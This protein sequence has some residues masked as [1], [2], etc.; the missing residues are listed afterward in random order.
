MHLYLAI[1]SNHFQTDSLITQELWGR[2]P[3]ILMGI[4]ARYPD[5]HAF[6]G[7]ECYI[8]DE[9]KTRIIKY[10]LLSGSFFLPLIQKAQEYISRDASR[11]HSQESQDIFGNLY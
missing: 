6:L 4:L 10:N 7:G 11:V 1:T 9:E 8:S 5:A 3:A 2:H